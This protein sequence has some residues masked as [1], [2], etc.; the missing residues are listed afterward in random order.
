[1]EVKLFV[2]EDKKY[3]SFHRVYLEAAGKR[4]RLPASHFE[5]LVLSRPDHPKRP[6]QGEKGLNRPICS[7]NL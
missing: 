7:L 4:N 1:M 5:S 2:V 3:R 6:I